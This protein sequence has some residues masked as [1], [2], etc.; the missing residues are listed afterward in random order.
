MNSNSLL[1]AKFS[2]FSFDSDKI[3]LISIVIFYFFNFVFIEYFPLNVIPLVFGIPFYFLVFVCDYLPID[4]KILPSWLSLV[5]LSFLAVSYLV[6]EK[7]GS[8]LISMEFLFF[9]SLPFIYLSVSRLIASGAL[10]FVLNC[11]SVFLIWQIFVVAGQIM[12]NIFGYGFNL[13]SYYSGEAGH[14]TSMLT[15]TFY[16][17]NDLA[18][19]C[20][21]IFIVFLLGKSRAPTLAKVSLS[22]CVFLAIVTVSRSVILFM[23]LSFA[24]SLL[25]RAFI[26]RL[27]F[28]LGVL[29]VFSLGVYLLQEKMSH[30]EF[31]SRIFLRLDSLW[32]IIDQ[33]FG[34]DGSI[35]IR[36][37]S[38]LHFFENLD[39]LNLGSVSLRDYSIFVDS[40]GEEYKLMGVNPH[41]F[42]IEISYWLGW[43][44]LLLLLSFSVSVRP[45]RFLAFIYAV[46]GF[47]LLSLVSSSIINNF[48]FF[49]AFFA[50]FSL[51]LLSPNQVY[52]TGHGVYA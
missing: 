47:F 31:V 51:T 7:G 30:L 17:A 41:S 44:G 15:G 26:P 46:S 12:N 36:L 11:F 23:A 32:S 1:K 38:Y 45:K 13:P 18:S 21:M 8:F 6:L 3:V 10:Q 34:G 50:A 37:G 52:D 4:K 9:F 5:C 27:L 24:L 19:S 14:Y 20:G 49:A 16:N 39:N 33:G 25:S 48:I 35:S 2:V 42:V 28:L 29:G 22:I 40:L 43:P